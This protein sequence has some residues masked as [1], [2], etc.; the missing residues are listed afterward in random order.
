MTSGAG[1]TGLLDVTVTIRGGQVLLDRV[2]LLAEPGELLVILG[3]SGSGKSTLLRTIAGFLPVAAGEVIVDGRPVTAGTAARNLAMVFENTELIPMM[4]VAENMAFGLRNHQVPAAEAAAKVS[5]RA[6]G[7]NLTGILRRKPQ[8]L[9]PGQRG[10]VGIGRALVREPHAFLLDEPLAHLDAQERI[11]MRQLIAE[12]VKALRVPTLYVTH[13]QSEAMAVADRIAMLRDGRLAQV[14]T[15]QEVFH[16]PVD[17]FVADFLGSHPMNHLRAVLVSA[18]G[19]AGYRVGARTLATWGPVPAGLAGHVGREVLLGLRSEGLA[20][21]VGDLHPD[22]AEL[23][24]VVR[25]VEHT[26][27]RSYV[28]VEVAG[29]RLRARFDGWTRVRPGDPIAVTVDP[30]QL[31]VFDPDTGRALHHPEP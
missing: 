29:E 2:T 1:R 18:G 6:E 22:R 14:G 5:R 28:T 19:M 17:L 30:A 13:D 8:G 21:G 20:E 4:D 23:P 3:P 25:S 9:S 26:G 15:P 12:S 31:H 10:Q 11:R 7:L 27:S 16:R 24:G